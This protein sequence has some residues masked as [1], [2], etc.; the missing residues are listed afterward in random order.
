MCISVASFYH[1]PSST[2]NFCLNRCFWNMSSYTS[3]KLCF[4]AENFCKNENFSN[5]SSCTW[6]K[7]CFST[8]NFCEKWKFFKYV[9]LY[10]KKSMFSHWKFLSEWKFCK[11]VQLYQLQLDNVQLDVQ[12]QLDVSSCDFLVN[13]ESRWTNPNF[14]QVSIPSFSIF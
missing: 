5:M 2:E 6:R 3:R 4:S 14:L 11:Y 13:F 12:L 7:L 8:E 9:Q 1:L 10:I